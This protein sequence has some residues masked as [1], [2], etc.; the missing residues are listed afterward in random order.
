MNKD[1]FSVEFSLNEILSIYEDLVYSYSE[2]LVKLK[3]SI[4]NHRS[5]GSVY[6]E[7][8]KSL[9]CQRSVLFSKIVFFQ[10]LFS[11]GNIVSDCD[12]AADINGVFVLFNSL[13][14]EYSDFCAFHR[15]NAS[16]AALYFM[17]G[18]D[19]DPDCNQEPDPEPEPEE[20]LKDFKVVEPEHVDPEDLSSLRYKIMFSPSLEL[21]GSEYDGILYPDLVSACKV[22]NKIDPASSG[23]YYLL[24]V[25][26][27]LDEVLAHEGIVI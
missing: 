7:M 12:C 1:Y 24:E 22:I 15:F 10:E 26:T 13:T 19:E 21:V 27:S 25:N 8:F 20:T 5:G 16:L 14:N 2:T 11:I 6:Y 9:D 23:D 4:Y 18:S 17:Q 3:D